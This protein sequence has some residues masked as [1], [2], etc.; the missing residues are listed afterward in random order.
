M[1]TITV[2]NNYDISNGHLSLTRITTKIVDFETSKKLIS[3][4]DFLSLSSLGKHFT[5]TFSF[6][7]YQI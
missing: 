3:T 5:I 6:L 4:K 2:E 7:L 1:K